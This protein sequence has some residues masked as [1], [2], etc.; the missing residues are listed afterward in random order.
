M[1]CSTPGT[2][3]PDNNPVAFPDTLTIGAGGSLL[4]LNV[5]VEATHSFV[6]DLV[7]TLVHQATGTSVTLIDRPGS[8]PG[9]GCSGDDVN[10]VLDD[11]AALAVEAQCVTPGPVAVSGTFAPNSVLAGFDTESLVGDWDLTVSD[12]AGADTGTFTK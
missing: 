11:E 2:A 3:I 10:A 1:Q 8:P 4:D 12:L 7:F 9:G 5:S 6:G